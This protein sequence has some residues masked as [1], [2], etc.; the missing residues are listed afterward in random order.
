MAAKGLSY[1]DIEEKSNGR[2][3]YGYVNSLVK[4]INKNPSVEKINALAVGLGVP[5]N[6]LIRVA[7]GI[8]LEERDDP[9]SLVVDEAIAES[10]VKLSPKERERVVKIVK[11]HLKPL[12]E[13]A[14]DMVKTAKGA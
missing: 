10:G 1:R 2:I 8:P 12:V 13:S 3:S 4:G 5:E 11:K 6:T 14:V 9:S 7:R